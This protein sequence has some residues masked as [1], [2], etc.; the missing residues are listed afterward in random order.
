MGAFADLDVAFHRCVLKQCKQRLRHVGRGVLVP[1]RLD[2]QGWHADVRRIVVSLA[3]GPVV[4]HVLDDAIGCAQ[5]TRVFRIR[6]GGPGGI[7]PRL[8]PAGGN[9]AGQFVLWHAC[10]PAFLRTLFRHRA[11]GAKRTIAADQKG[12]IAQPQ[13]R[14]QHQ[15]VDL[16]VVGRGIGAHDRGSPRPAEQA[17]LR[18]AA[19]LQ[20]VVDRGAHIAHGNIGSHRRRAVLRRLVHLGRA[21]RTAVA[22]QVDQPHI[23]ALGGEIV[24]PRHAIEPEIESGFRRI[25]R[26]MDI[27]K[28]AVG[29]RSPVLQV[30]V[31]QE[32]LDPGRVGRYAQVF[33]CQFR[34]LFPDGVVV[35]EGACAAEGKQREGRGGQIIADG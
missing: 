12:R 9:Q 2:Q 14:I 35:R 20:D 16:V 32:Q 28:H 13:R 6:I 23:P 15:L 30:L 5:K 22:P 24:H 29:G 10:E 4:A 17:Q 8:E 34:N 33:R 27:E 18:Y 7:G 25:G 11:I 26:A 21:R 19:A 3:R 31:A 1:F